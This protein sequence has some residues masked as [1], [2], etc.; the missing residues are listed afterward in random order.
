MAQ[1]AHCPKCHGEMNVLDVVC[2]HCGYDFPDPPSAENDPALART[3]IAYS[4]WAE[5]ALSIGSVAASILCVGSAVGSIV[6]IFSGQFF[7]GLVAGPLS[8]FLSLAMLVVF[9]RVQKL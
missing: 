7:Q 2:P 1:I 9:I 6:A 8:F 5:I 3:G 4:A